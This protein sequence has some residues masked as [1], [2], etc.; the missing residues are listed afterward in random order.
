MLPSSQLLGEGVRE[1]TVALLNVSRVP[2]WGATGAAPSGGEGE[3]VGSFS[4]LLKEHVP[5]S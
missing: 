5:F 4:Y 1:A 2:V 3:G